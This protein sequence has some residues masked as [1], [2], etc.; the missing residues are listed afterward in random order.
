MPCKMSVVVPVF[1]KEDSLEECI[2][3][4]VRQ[5][6]SHLSFEVI[7]PALGFLLSY[8]QEELRPSLSGDAPS[9]R[10]ERLRSDRVE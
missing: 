2:S 9:N 4:P 8:R 6:E 1:N 3:S 10:I 5:N 7:M